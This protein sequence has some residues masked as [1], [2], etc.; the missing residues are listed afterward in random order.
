MAYLTIKNLKILDF[1]LL[2]KENREKNK[3]K[4]QKK[5]KNHNKK[6]EKGFFLC[7]FRLLSLCSKFCPVVTLSQPF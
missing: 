2:A 7:M 5:T 3:L 4:S 6:D 1:G